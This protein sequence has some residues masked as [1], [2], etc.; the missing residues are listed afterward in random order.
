MQDTVQGNFKLLPALYNVLRVKG[1][2]LENSILSLVSLEQ[3]ELRRMRS[4]FHLI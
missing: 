4:L 3:K 1:V 2:Q